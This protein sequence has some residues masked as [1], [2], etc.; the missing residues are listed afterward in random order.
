MQYA[1]QEPAEA[2]NPKSEIRNPQSEPRLRLGFLDGIRAA[3][4]LYVVF[5][6]AYQELL[7]RSQGGIPSAVL[8]SLRFL[9][10]GHY[11]VDIFIVLSGYCLMLPVAR[12]LSGELRGGIGQYVFRRA[13]RILPPYYA[14]VIFSLLVITAVAALEHTA[15]S[16]QSIANAFSPGVL[17]SHVA[18]IHNLV[19]GASGSINPPL[20]SV[21][22]EWQI[23]FLFPLLL[24]PIWRKFG[25]TAALVIGTAVGML[26]VVFGATWM[27]GAAPWYI[28]LFAM[29][30]LAAVLS[31]S[32]SAVYSWNRRMP[33]G[34][35]TTTLSAVF[36][37]IGV[38]KMGW[39][40]SNRW[41]ADILAGAAAMALILTCVA[42]VR[43]KRLHHPVLRVLESKMA[44]KLGAFSYSIYL[45]HYPLLQLA[46][47]TLFRMDVA[48]VVRAVVML[49]LVP[50]AIVGVAY[51]F[52]LVFERKFMNP[53]A[54]DA[55]RISRAAV[56]SAA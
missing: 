28:G 56:R 43:A 11:A 4:A 37:T 39:Y 15:A 44:V 14:A 52:H 20:W 40:Q 35:I 29:G 31:F 42:A 34:A 17:L 33:W 18:L 47:V 3:A 12:S 21:G 55:L 49:T 24:L 53:G 16:S 32:T 9:A 48:P 5:H 7:Y 51:L 36:F 23:Y 2:A 50:V 10:F 6:H 30:M 45:V 8:K 1:L 13:R 27:Y 25:V 46:H 22:T 54:P 38:V 41:V 26:P 19:P